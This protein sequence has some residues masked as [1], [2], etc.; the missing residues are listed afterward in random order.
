MS[1][2]ISKGKAKIIPGSKT[3]FTLYLID[4]Q[5]RPIS[6][7]PYSAGKLVFLNLSGVRTEIALSVPGINPVAGAINVNL[8]ALQTAP[9]DDKWINADIE[10]TEGADTVVLPINDVFEIVKRNVPPAV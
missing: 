4:E 8:T 7:A 9:A 10:L 5:N 6:L 2:C 1:S 3:S